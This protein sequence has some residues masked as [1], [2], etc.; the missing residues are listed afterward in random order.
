MNDDL[1][2]LLP[3]E[4]Q[5][6]LSREYRMR[7]GVVA[8]LLLTSLACASGLLLLPTYVLLT[9]SAAAKQA[10]LTNVES[11]LSSADEK[12]LAAHLA[13][14]SND[15]VTL[16]ALG[17]APSV[18]AIL[19]NTLAIPRPGITLSGFSYTPAAPNTAGKLT[20]SG[21]A[22]TRDTLR[23]YQIV[24]Q[25]APFAAKADL[26]VSAY[27]KDADISFTITITLTP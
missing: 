17:K 1:T 21:T 19:R 10:N 2:N 18:S 20:V 24:L 3:P 23:S 16:I 26:P 22:L 9:Q 27:A 8:A 11:V 6:A 4:R 25:G 12:A 5:R 7:L 13:V 15:A 14:L